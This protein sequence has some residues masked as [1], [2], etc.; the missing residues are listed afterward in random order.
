[1]DD[2]NPNKKPI[3]L[4][5]FMHEQEQRKGIN[6]IEEQSPGVDGATVAQLLNASPPVSPIEKRRDS[7]LPTRKRLEFDED[8]ISVDEKRTPIIAWNN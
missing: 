4:Q 6:N 7:D 5:E 2:Y 3:S 1:M 8:K